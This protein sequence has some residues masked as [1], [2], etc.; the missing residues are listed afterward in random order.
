MVGVRARQDSKTQPSERRELIL[1]GLESWSLWWGSL[2]TPVMV[3]M[4][5]RLKAQP[6]LTGIWWFPQSWATWQMDL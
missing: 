4:V 1:L 2:G 3:V 5:V 6:S